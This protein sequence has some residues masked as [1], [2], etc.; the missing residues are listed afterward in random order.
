MVT[1]RLFSV[2]FFVLL[3]GFASDLQDRSLGEPPAVVDES[4]LTPDRTSPEAL[5]RGL[6]AARRRGDLAFLARCDLS[7]AGKGKLDTLDVARAWRQ[8]GWRS[9]EPFWSKVETALNGGLFRTDLNGARATLVFDV[10][11]AL[12]EIEL[13]FEGNIGGWHLDTG[14]RS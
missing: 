12:G 5:L 9:V 6:L 4:T 10:G 2:A 13:L 8:F 7:T 1:I 11:G 14:G 3:T